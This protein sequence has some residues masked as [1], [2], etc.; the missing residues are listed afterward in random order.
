MYRTILI[1]TKM[2]HINTL[3]GDHYTTINVS[4]DDI[5]YFDLFKYIKKPVHPIYKNYDDVDYD[6][7][8]C[9]IFEILIYTQIHLSHN[10]AEVNIFDKINFDI[11]HLMVHFTQKYCYFN[12][13]F[14]DD[15][16]EN[17]E[18]GNELEMIDSQTEKMCEEFIRRDPLNI[19][20]VKDKTENLCKL[21]V[22]LQALVIRYIPSKMKTYEL[23]T[24][25]ILYNCEAFKFVPDECKI[26]DICKHC[27]CRNGYLLKYVPN[28]MKTPKICKYAVDD[29]PEAF[30]YIPDK[31][32]TYEICKQVVDES[33]G[34]M[35]EYIPD[36]YKNNLKN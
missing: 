28:D 32:K 7:G 15:V 36:K 13:G 22:E 16:H 33:L 11:D 35:L 20:F 3:S 24:I 30:I 5:D 8:T 27:V 1:N 4:E 29:R 18:L 14:D 31:M 6:E 19:I 10:G 9:D 17:I 21:A 34:K 2:I 23:C 25:A 26:Y 12:G